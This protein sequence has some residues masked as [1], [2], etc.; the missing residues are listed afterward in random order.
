MLWFC[1]IC[2]KLHPKITDFIQ[3][4]SVFYFLFSC[5]PVLVFCIKCDAL[6]AIFRWLEFLK[7]KESV[8]ITFQQTTSRICWQA[9]KID[10]TWC[11][12]SYLQI[13]IVLIAFLCF[14]ACVFLENL[15][16][17]FSS[18]C[19]LNLGKVFPSSYAYLTEESSNTDF[20]LLF[21]PACYFL[22]DSGLT[23]SNAVFVKEIN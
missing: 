21:P 12:Y 10:T 3:F 7:P 20:C 17:L 14:F 2:I 15:Y 18:M 19:S 5:H 4:A 23:G 11:M 16:Q 8:S 13:Y 6:A 1:Y 22:F 9:P